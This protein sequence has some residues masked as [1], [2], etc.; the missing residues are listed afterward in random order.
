MNPKR[1]I[2][3][4]AIALAISGI[5]TYWLS[6]KFSKPKGTTVKHQ[7]V[8]AALNLEAGE[9]LKPANL[10]LIDWPE[11]SNLT[12][13]FAKPEEV[14]GRVVLYP[15]SAGQP[16]LER[17]LSAA[18]T[19]LGLT[20]KIPDG[21][22]AI[23]LRS[24]DVV[25]V[26]GFLLP[27]T[28]VDVLVTYHTANTSDPITTTILQ[29]VEILAAGQKFQPDPEGKANSVNVVTL[30]VKPTDA[31]RVVLASSQGIVHF[32]LRNGLDREQIKGSSMQ[33][34]Q[35][36]GSQVPHPVAPM[37]SAPRISAPRAAPAGNS[38]YVV[39]TVSGGKQS[40]ESF[41]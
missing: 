39:E 6:Q 2:T 37:N 4:L 22:R 31:E 33:L 29:D 21:M 16:I 14:A 11:T 12:G 13:A 24:D 36:D 32:V 17:Q 7:Y 27:G 35:L 25:G 20:V 34:S 3:A 8:A 18:G 15:L 9:M 5:F 30:L 26:A 41:K 19:G 23:S 40:V 38:A 1:L 10:N 28:H